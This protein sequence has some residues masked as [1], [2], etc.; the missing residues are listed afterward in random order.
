MIGL[1]VELQKSLSTREQG[2]CP[3]SGKPYSETTAGN[4]YTVK[5]IFYHKTEPGGTK[6]Y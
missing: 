1:I 6:M 2:V 3:R 5:R 4:E